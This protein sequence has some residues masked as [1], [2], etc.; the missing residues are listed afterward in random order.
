MLRGLVF[1]RWFSLY[2][3]LEIQPHNQTSIYHYM[4]YHWGNGDQTWWATFAEAGAHVLD[5]DHV[6]SMFIRA[7]S[8][9]I[10]SFSFCPGFRR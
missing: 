2:L 3:E 5:K 4:N 9:P 6:V 10:G 1:I 7:T 8:I